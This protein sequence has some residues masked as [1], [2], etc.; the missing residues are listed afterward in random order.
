MQTAAQPKPAPIPARPRLTLKVSSGKLTHAKWIHVYGPEGVGKSTLGAGAPSP[1]FIDV[2]QGTAN[3]DTNRFQFDEGRTLPLDWLEFLDAVRLIEKE[4]HS[5]RTLVIDTLDAVEALIWQHI[6]KR[7]GHETIIDYGFAKGENV[8]ALA[9]WRQLV[10]ILE[11][12]RARG[13]NVITLSHSMVK[14][15][16]DPESDGWDRYILKLHE[17]AGG[18]VKER[19]DAV[20]FARF[21][22]VLQKK[23]KGDGK[24]LKAIVTDRRMLCTRKTGAYDAKNRDDLPHE[25]PLDWAELWGALQAHR[26]AEPAAL[27]ETIKANLERLI[28]VKTTDGR[29]AKEVATVALADAGGDAVKLSKLNTWVNSKIGEEE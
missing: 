12:I 17:K 8:V 9:E 29:D 6:C 2:E 11:R 15:F 24:K 16:D 7:D 19:A 21:E 4:A 13:L 23:G 28:G 26:P 20:L 25:L 14:H 18:L 27:V 3:I 1:L 10:A 22:Q 5:Y